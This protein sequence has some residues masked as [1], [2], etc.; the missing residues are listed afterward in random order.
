[1]EGYLLKK[2]RGESK[3]FGRRNWKKRWCVLDGQYFTYYED[4]DREKNTPV[5]KKVE[6]ILFFLSFS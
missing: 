1:M 3:M 2:G 6:L 5:N 4:F